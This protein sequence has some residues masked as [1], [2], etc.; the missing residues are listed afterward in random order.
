VRKF[1]VF[2]KLFQEDAAKPKEETTVP[3]DTQNVINPRKKLKFRVMVKFSYD[4]L[5]FL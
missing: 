3:V 4:G 5:V 1:N 2:S